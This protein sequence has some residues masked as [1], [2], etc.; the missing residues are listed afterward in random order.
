MDLHDAENLI[1]HHM[2]DDP[3]DLTAGQLRALLKAAV[4]RAACRRCHLVTV[5]GRDGTDETDDIIVIGCMARSEHPDRCD[6]DTLANQIDEV[7]A[8]AADRAARLLTRIQVLAEQCAAWERAGGA[9]V[10]ALTGETQPVVSGPH[11][12]YAAARQGRR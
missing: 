1:E 7:R 6:C 5:P 12:L 10:R 8:V 2:P 9:A 4:E 3:I 11:T